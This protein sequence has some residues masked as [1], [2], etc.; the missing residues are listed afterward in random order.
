LARNSAGRSRASRGNDED[1]GVADV[2]AWILKSARGGRGARG[3][4]CETDSA[5]WLET[6]KQRSWRGLIKSYIR[7]VEVIYN[8]TTFDGIV[9]GMTPDCCK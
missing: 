4:L 9:G 8:E 6:R 2:R 5:T 3:L 1:I 7:S